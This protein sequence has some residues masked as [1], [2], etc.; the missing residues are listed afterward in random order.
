MVLMSFG[1]LIIFGFNSKRL[2]KFLMFPKFLKLSIVPL[3]L[4]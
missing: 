3:L 4:H 1:R 2:P